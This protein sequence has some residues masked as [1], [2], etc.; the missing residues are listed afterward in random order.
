V[1]DIKAELCAISH[2]HRARHGQ[3]ICLNPFNVLGLG[4]SGFNPIA[5][6]ETND[7]FCDDALEL[8]EAII[9]IEGSEPHWSQAAQELVA[10]LIMYVRLVMPNVGSFADVRDLLGRDDAGI[11]ILVKGGSD[12]DPKRYQEWLKTPEEERDPSYAPP[13]EHRGKLYPGMIAAAIIHDWPELENKITRFGAISAADREMHS[14]FSTALTQTR[15]LDS[16]PVRRD[17]AK[18]PIDFSI[19]KDRPVTIYLILPA[20]RL[21]THSSWLRLAIA[22]VVQKLMKDTRKANTPFL[23]MLDEYYAIAEGDSF[24]Y[25]SRLMP[26][27]RGFGLKMWTVW[28]DMSQMDALYERAFETFLS[29]AGVVQ[30]FAPQD[31]RTAEYLSQRLGQTMRQLITTSESRQPNPGA[32]MGMA[33]S[34]GLNQSLLQLPLMLPQDIRNLGEG[35]TLVL[36]HVTNGAVR[37]YVPWPADL[38]RYRRIMSLDP[39][40]T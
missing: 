13:V 18:N 33:V 38:S 37:S 11:R 12:I 3:I 1:V 5:A 21:A 28:Q 40:N 7:D 15:W 4:S 8:A 17:L 16:R 30:C 39:A 20:R 22:S 32:P 23:L 24:P 6:L 10:A 35:F 9:R 14:V 34:Y 27:M 31:V 25:L 19:L 2:K 29:N 26:V 36:S